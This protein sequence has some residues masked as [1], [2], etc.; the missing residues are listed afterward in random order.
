MFH[1]VFGCSYVIKPGKQSLHWMSDQAD[2]NWISVI[3]L[4]EVDEMHVL[5]IS[6][7]SRAWLAQF[8]YMILLI[9]K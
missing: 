8:F 2:V 5:E 6:T 4:V 1:Q 7:F 3:E 9:S